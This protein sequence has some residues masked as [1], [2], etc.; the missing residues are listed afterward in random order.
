[1]RK[2]RIFIVELVLVGLL[3]AWIFWKFP[4]LVDR[5][6]PWILVAILWHLT[7]EIASESITVRSWIVDSAGRLGRMSWIVVFLVGGCLSLIYLRSARTAISE[8]AKEAAE[9][10][11]HVR[12]YILVN[13]NG[14]S[15]TQESPPSPAPSASASTQSPE[16][17]AAAPPETQPKSQYPDITA[18]FIYAKAPSLVILNPSGTIAREIKWSVAIW[19]MDIPE[20]NDPLPVPIATFDW[21]RPHSESGP[22]DLF[23]IPTVA[24][25]IKPGDHLFG[26]VSIICPECTR[27]RTYIVYVIWGEGGWFSEDKGEKSGGLIIPPNFLRE[28]RET[29]FRQLEEMYPDST[30]TPIS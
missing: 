23:G 18:R 26:S 15:T 6:I 25:L 29:Y 30:R 14:G 4:N 24:P 3:V 21:I 17:K 7:W 27:G 19:N 10:T 22:L 11:T 8:L 28:T 2:L 13:G 5:V 1:M 20:R 16:L 9:S 12:S